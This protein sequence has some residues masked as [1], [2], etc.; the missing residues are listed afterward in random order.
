MSTTTVPKST[1]AGIAEVISRA[2]AEIN[3][4]MEDGERREI[5]IRTVR[6][7]STLGPVAWAKV[8]ASVPI[9]AKNF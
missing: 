2:V 4:R 6:N 5:A 8:V 3:Y 1:Q 7:R 9:T